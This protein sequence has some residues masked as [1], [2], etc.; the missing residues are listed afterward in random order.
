MF[1]GSLSA[2]AV[3]STGN[4]LDILLCVRLGDDIDLSWVLA[5]VC[6]AELMCE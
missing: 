6:H 3:T 5:S 1:K 2:A 4:P